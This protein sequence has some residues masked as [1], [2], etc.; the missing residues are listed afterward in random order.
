MSKCSSCRKWDAELDTTWD[1]IRLKFF[2]LFAKDI[3]D[4]SQEKFTQGFADGYAMGQKH[5][6]RDK[7]EFRADVFNNAVARHLDMSGIES[8]VSISEEA[9]E[10]A[11]KLATQ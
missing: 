4:L 8:T 9:Y 3:I 2:H 7:V 10:E 1:R 11:K 5:A 6:E